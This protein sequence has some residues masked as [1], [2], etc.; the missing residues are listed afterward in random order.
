MSVDLRDFEN[1]SN[2]Q[3]MDGVLNWPK[4]ILLVLPS[5]NRISKNLEDC[6]AANF[7][8]KIKMII[9]WK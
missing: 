4:Y 6:G 3:T 7:E 9:Y 5:S 2:I 1:E 8:N